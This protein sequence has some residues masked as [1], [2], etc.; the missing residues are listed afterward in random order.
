[1]VVIHLLLAL[2]L[3]AVDL[4]VSIMQILSALAV[5]V[6]VAVGHLLLGFCQVGLEQ[7]VKETLA[8]IVAHKLLFTPLAAVVAL[9]LV[10]QLEIQQINL[11]QVVLAQHL[12]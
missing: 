4:A 10:A 3:L 2:L 12:Q 11:V 8:E 7:A 1:M 5:L 9:V 6:V